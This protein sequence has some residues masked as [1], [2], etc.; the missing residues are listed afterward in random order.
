MSIEFCS[1]CSRHIDTDW[2][3]EGEYSDDGYTCERC[4]I[5]RD[6]I[7]EEERE[8]EIAAHG[9]FGVGA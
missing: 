4:C 1:A 9:P 3:V 5:K 6:E 8:E 7:L 2:N